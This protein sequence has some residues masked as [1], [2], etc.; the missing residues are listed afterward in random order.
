MRVLAVDDSATIRRIIKN[1]R[2]VAPGAPALPSVPAA[3]D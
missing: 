1:Q 3:G 2:L